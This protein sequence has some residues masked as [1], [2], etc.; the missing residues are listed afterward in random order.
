MLCRTAHECPRRF[1]RVRGK[2]PLGWLRTGSH[3]S[4]ADGLPPRPDRATADHGCGLLE[5]L[6]PRWVWHGAVTL[7]GG[8][9]SATSPPHA[10][11]RGSSSDYG[12]RGRIEAAM[13]VAPAR[14]VNRPAA[15]IAAGQ[16]W[17]LGYPAAG[18][19]LQRPPAYYARSL[20][21]TGAKPD[22]SRYT[23][24]VPCSLPS[25]PLR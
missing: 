11:Q 8:G 13:L 3:C 16:A 2:A 18:L 15:G 6:G 9:E 4:S 1:L 24:G 21:I 20:H 7:P 25:P 10:K 17:P 19:C 5:G 12:D 14:V 22:I 23:C